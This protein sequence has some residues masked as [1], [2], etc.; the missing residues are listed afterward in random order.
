MNVTAKNEFLVIGLCVDLQ[1]KKSFKIIIRVLH[2][3]LQQMTTLVS[4]IYNSI[5]SA[6]NT[7]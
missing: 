1:P 6:C 4:S 3:L 7:I 2:Q 5:I